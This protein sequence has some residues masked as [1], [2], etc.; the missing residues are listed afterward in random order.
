MN[1]RERVLNF[2]KVADS[3]AQTHFWKQVMDFVGWGARFAAWMTNFAEQIVI[4]VGSGEWVVDHSDIGEWV[5]GRP[6][7]MT[8]V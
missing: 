6:D 5:M 7:W 1:I 3:R 4:R 2:S 8:N